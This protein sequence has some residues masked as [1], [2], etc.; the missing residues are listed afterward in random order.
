MSISRSPYWDTLA[1]DF[2]ISRAVVGGVVTSTQVGCALALLLFVPLGDRADRRRLMAWQLLGLVAT[3]FVVATAPST[4]VL[5]VGMLAVGMLGTAMTQGL[6]AY[7]A[8]AAL[9]EEQGRLSVW[10]RAVCSLACFWPASMQ[11][12][13]VTLPAGRTSV[14]WARR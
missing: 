6:I 1:H 4:P 5:L 14:F 9:P 13:S 10:C 3:L 2:Y 7:A 12:V 8:S 11:A